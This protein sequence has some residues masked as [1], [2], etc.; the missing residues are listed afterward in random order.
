MKTP[1]LLITFNRPHYTAEML[2][3]LKDAEVENLYIFK[4]GPRPDNLDDYKASIEIENLVATIDWPCNV[5]TLYMTNNLGCGYGPYTAISWVFNH[6]DTLIILEDDCVPTRTFF[7]F[8]SDMLSRYANDQR[9][10]VVS[11]RCQL[12]DATA[13]AGK[14]YIFTQFAPTWGWATWKRVWKGF[15][16]QMR[17]VKAFFDSGG[18]TIQ[19]GTK[20]ECQY[21]NRRFKKDYA[22]SKL[23]THVWDN[24]FGYHSRINGALRIM[25][26]KNLIQYIGIEGTHS[27]DGTADM[28]AFSASEDF[29]AVRHPQDVELD[30]QYDSLYF[31][32][33]INSP[34][35]LSERIL[36]SLKYRLKRIISK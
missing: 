25:P 23:L 33:F 27:G 22:D 12:Y 34:L 21:M 20:K 4:D 28:M 2:K 29:K 8:C 6:E 1:V 32:R 3:A 19:F 30:K 35:T 16:I 11:G 24:Q 10:S 5:K 14:D 18:F 7:Q 26:A 31:N 36:A 17:N 9:V 15:D 13:F